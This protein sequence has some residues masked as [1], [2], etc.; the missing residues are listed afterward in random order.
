MPTRERRLKSLKESQLAALEASE[1]QEIEQPEPE[2]PESDTENQPETFVSRL[3]SHGL[4]LSDLEI[5]GARGSTL[6]PAQARFKVF[7]IADAAKLFDETIAEFQFKTEQ[8]RLAREALAAIEQPKFRQPKERENPLFDGLLEQTENARDEASYRQIIAAATGRVNALEQQLLPL[9]Q[10]A[11]CGAFLADLHQLR[12]QIAPKID[13]YRGALQAVEEI[14]A[15]MI[16]AKAE[17][18]AA[19]PRFKEGIIGH[20]IPVNLLLPSVDMGANLPAPP[21]SISQSYQRDL[22]PMQKLGVRSPEEIARAD[23]L[24]N[25][26][27]AKDQFVD[28]IDPIVPEVATP[29]EARRLELE[30]W[31][32]ERERMT[33]TGPAG[34]TRVPQ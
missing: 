33:P 21:P 12:S 34:S 5:A 23:F 29:E 3:R 27:P 6:P 30:T 7:N 22:F 4:Q 19:W 18:L 11:I 25:L 17:A 28:D 8:V 13:R 9:K 20:Y 31:R 2:Q 1:A 32:F 24:K 10:A 14:R 16:A 26:S 15:E